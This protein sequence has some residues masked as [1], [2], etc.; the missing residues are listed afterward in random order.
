MLPD[1]ANAIVLVHNLLEERSLVLQTEQSIK[2]SVSFAHVIDEDGSAGLVRRLSNPVAIVEGALVAI[3][4]ILGEVVQRQLDV[5]GFNFLRRAV[6]CR[7]WVSRGSELEGSFDF[8]VKLHGR[9]VG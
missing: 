7:R 1:D 8:R 3:V 6:S 4:L 2:L 9:A 5:F